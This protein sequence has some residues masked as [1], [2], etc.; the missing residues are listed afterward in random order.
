MKAKRLDSLNSFPQKPND[1]PHPDFIVSLKCPNNYPI[2]RLENFC[3]RKFQSF[4]TKMKVY[5]V[6]SFLKERLLFTIEYKKGYPQW[7]IPKGADSKWINE[8]FVLKALKRL[9]F[10]TKGRGRNTKIFVTRKKINKKLGKR[11]R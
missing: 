2:H 3:G 9:G 11:R 10:K 5:R 4:V 8:E 6:L 7:Y 1:D